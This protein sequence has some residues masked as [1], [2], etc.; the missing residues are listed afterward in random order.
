V[1][2]MEPLGEAVATTAAAVLRAVVAAAV[3]LA[4]V[5]RG[6]AP[7]ALPLSLQGSVRAMAL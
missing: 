2:V 6:Q 7:L 5:P 3:E 4:V 1:K